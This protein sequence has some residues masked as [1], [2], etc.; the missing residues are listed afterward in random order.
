MIDHEDPSE[1]QIDLWQ[2]E[3]RLEYEEGGVKVHRG[4]FRVDAYGAATECIVNAIEVGLASGSI[5]QGAETRT[6]EAL[7]SMLFALDPDLAG[8]KS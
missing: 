8:E 6:L 1:T 3:S 2:E 4:W 7:R 5:G